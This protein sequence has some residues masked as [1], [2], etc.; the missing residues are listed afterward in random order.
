[1]CRVSIDG[2]VSQDSLNDRY[3]IAE[4]PLLDLQA[5]GFTR[6][7]AIGT[8]VAIFKS[9][10]ELSGFKT[11]IQV[12]YL[13]GDTFKVNSKDIENLSKL[14]NIRHGKKRDGL[15]GGLEKMREYVRALDSEYDVD[16]ALTL[17]HM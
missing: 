7:E 9:V 13:K 2:R 14:I 6:K 3:W 1:M 15:S 5:Q 16:L 10:S 8:L 4:L 12:D 17:S 11:D